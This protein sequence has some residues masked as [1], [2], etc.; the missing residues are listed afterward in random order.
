LADALDDVD[1][2]T[3]LS[4]SDK[5]IIEAMKSIEDALDPTIK[6]KVSFFIDYLME[7]VLLIDISVSSESEAHRVFVTM[8]D[9]GL[10]LGAIEL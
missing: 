5:R 1:S 6:E 8:N 3:N 7:K 4:D 2:I 10:R 9:R